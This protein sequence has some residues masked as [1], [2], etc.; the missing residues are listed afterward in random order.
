LG[1]PGVVHV[2]AEITGFDVGMPEDGS[3]KEGGKEDGAELHR[4]GESITRVG[5]EKECKSEKVQGAKANHAPDPPERE[6]GR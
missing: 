3:E 4:D 5:K 6:K 1:K 2:A